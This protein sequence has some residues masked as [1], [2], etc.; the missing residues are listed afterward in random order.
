MQQELLLTQGN[1]V[2]LAFLIQ[3]LHPDKGTY[4]G[5]CSGKEGCAPCMGQVTY[6]LGERVAHLTFFIPPEDGVCRDCS[7]LIDEMARQAGDL[8]ALAILGEIEETHPLFETLR[9]CGF[10]VYASQRIW[11]MPEED[12][13]LDPA[14]SWTPAEP[15]HIPALQ[16]LHQGLIPASILA[17]EGMINDFRHIL[18]YQLDGAVMGSVYI[19]YG[20]TGIYFQPVFSPEV[21]Q[22][23]AAVQALLNS[24]PRLGRNMSAAIRSDQAWIEA[25]L[26]YLGARPVSKQARMAKHLALSNRSPA[27]ALNHPM[28]ETRQTE[29]TSSLIPYEDSNNP[30][31]Q[32]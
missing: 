28:R 20:P 10:N 5:I 26:E 14:G 4:T 18:V 30:H 23:A 2:G 31:P 32:K 11:C 19:I 13:G 16:N 9:H 21:V 12:P 7:A 1:P 22:P 17:A 3:S 8:G 24:T 27:F 29:P 25:A 6:P 15:V